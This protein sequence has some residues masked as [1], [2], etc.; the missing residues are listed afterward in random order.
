MEF[1]DSIS[2]Y[3]MPREKWLELRRSGIGGSD[4]PAL[5]LPPDK[6]KWKR[7]IDVYN[8]KVL[9]EESE[10]GLAAAV[11]THLEPFVANL[12]T[13]ETGIK[14]RKL[15]KFLRN[16]Q[17]PW[18]TANIDRKVYDSLYGLE[19]KTTS[20]F[21]DKKF[22]EEDFPPEYYVQILHYLAVTGW[23]RWY[24]AVLIGNHRF[25]WYTVERNE[26][27]IEE[28]KKVEFDFWKNIIQK[29][30]TKELEEK[31]L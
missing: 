30:N 24:L 13:A 17:Y 10:C 21:N 1:D 12:F 11:G 9:G 15:N 20:A 7:P 25:A 8:A 29:Q 31:W 5:M 2:T 16:K 28:L 3:R 18:M 19:I 4:A 14:V 22:T 23:V 27:D 6:F 26:E